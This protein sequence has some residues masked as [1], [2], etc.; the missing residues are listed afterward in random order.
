MTKEQ[1]EKSMAAQLRKIWKTYKDYVPDGKY[2]NLTIVDGVLM[3][4]D[5]VDDRHINHMEEL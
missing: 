3:F 4:W 2:L 5:A 1:V